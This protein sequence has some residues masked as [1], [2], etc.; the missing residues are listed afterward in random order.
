MEVPQRSKAKPACPLHLKRS[1]PSSDLESAHR[2][3]PP[4]PGPSASSSISV[5]APFAASQPGEIVCACQSICSVPCNLQIARAA[6]L[7][8]QEELAQWDHG[9]AI[10][11]SAVA[12][13]LAA[14]TAAAAR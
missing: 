11:A 1:G 3:A 6:V 10:H 14:L 8:A 9:M 4:C 5:A 12:A 2:G 7:I 13:I